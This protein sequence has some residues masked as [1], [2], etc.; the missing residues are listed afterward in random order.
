MLSLVW[1]KCRLY[2]RALQYVGGDWCAHKVFDKWIEYE[3]GQ[4]SVLQLAHVYKQAIATTTEDLR[5]LHNA[6]V[7]F[8]SQNDSKLL[9]SEDE[10]AGMVVKVRYGLVAYPGRS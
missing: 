8:V 6:F 10:H 5:R 4:G 9:M 7:E 1:S 3:T 2:G